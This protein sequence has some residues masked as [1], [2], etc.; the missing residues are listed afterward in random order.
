[1]QMENCCK[2]LSILITVYFCFACTDDTLTPG[3]TESDTGPEV[4]EEIVR[5]LNEESD[6][7]VKKNKDT[8]NFE[9]PAEICQPLDSKY[10]KRSFGNGPERSFCK[11]WYRKFPWL[12]YDEKRDGSILLS[13]HEC[14]QQV[15]AM[16]FH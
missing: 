5:R 6:K 16:C 12:H 11:E 13:M 15:E 10:P 1:M 8:R 2:M 14:S 7:E 4:R 9:L 3:Q